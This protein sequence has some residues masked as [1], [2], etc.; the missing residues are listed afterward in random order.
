MWAEIDGDAEDPNVKEMNDLYKKHKEM[1]FSVQTGFR[2][3]A[4]PN[5]AT[6]V[7]ADA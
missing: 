4:D 2:Y 6:F 3:W 7:G 1:D 5:S